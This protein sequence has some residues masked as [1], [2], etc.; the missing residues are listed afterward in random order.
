LILKGQ[1]DE[2]RRVLGSHF[3]HHLR[4]VAL[5]RPVADLHQHGAFLVGIA[6]AD[7]AQ[8]LL[9][10]RRQRFRAGAAGIDRRAIADLN[11]RLAVWMAG[12]R[13]PRDGLSRDTDRVVFGDGGFE[14]V[15]HFVNQRAN[16]LGFPEGAVNDLLERIVDQ[17]IAALLDI[18]DIKQQSRHRPVQFVRYRR[19]D[20]AGEPRMHRGK[21]SDFKI[22]GHPLDA[23]CGKRNGRCFVDLRQCG[24]PAF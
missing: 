8:D 10:A 11:T 24:N 1:P 20:L 19:P 12:P 4:P 2:F 23:S 7:Q 6:R 14:R 17:S 5:E 13:P 22:V 15:G 16:S 18:S 21:P 3:S 9:F